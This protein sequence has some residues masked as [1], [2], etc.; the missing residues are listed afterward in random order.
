MECRTPNPFCDAVLVDLRRT[1]E[2]ISSL[3][4]FANATEVRDTAARLVQESIDRIAKEGQNIGIV[5]RPTPPPPPPPAAPPIPNDVP[6]EHLKAAIEFANE[7][8][9]E[10]AWERKFDIDYARTIVRDNR[11][12]SMWANAI[13]WFVHGARWQL[14]R[15]ERAYTGDDPTM[16]H[17]PANEVQDAERAQYEK[18]IE[19]QREKIAELE[20]RFAA[21][22]LPTPTEIS[23]AWFDRPNT[24]CPEAACRVLALFM[25][26]RELRELSFHEASRRYS[27]TK[28][29]SDADIE[30]A[31]NWFLNNEADSFVGIAEDFPGSAKSIA[32]LVAATD[33]PVPQAKEESNGAGTLF[34]EDDKTMFRGSSGRGTIVGSP[35]SMANPIVPLVFRDENERDFWDEQVHAINRRGDRTPSDVANAADEMV[36]ER[37][38]RMRV[39]SD[40]PETVDW[41]LQVLANM[42]LVAEKDSFIDR[43][44]ISLAKDWERRKRCFSEMR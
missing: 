35:E 26:K 34:I 18:T 40:G 16:Y 44:R 41:Q 38:K 7:T 13:R 1:H 30:E 43:F 5:I 21:S 28:R 27:M 25:S 29:P 22:D 39:E 3:A 36:E 19:L 42:R 11:G 2:S 12:I 6:D 37:R 23:E 24:V 9:G 20:S 10:Q 15:I 31:R 17:P 32:I 8:V 14:A 33:K 4:A